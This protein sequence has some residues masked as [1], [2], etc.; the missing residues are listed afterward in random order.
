MGLQ[1]ECPECGHRNPEGEVRCKGTIRYRENK[2]KK[3][4][5]AR[6]TK[7]S[8]KIYWIPRTWKAEAGTH[9]AE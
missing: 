8:G 6:L 4:E 9:W 1:V 2:G 7:T 3:C 5:F